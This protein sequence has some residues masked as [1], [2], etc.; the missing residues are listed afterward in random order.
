ME[1]IDFHT[2]ILPEMDDGA[3]TVEE[4]IQMLRGAYLSGAQTVLLTPHYLGREPILD[5][6]ARRKEKIAKLKDAM[7]DDGGLFPKLLAGAEVLLKGALSEHDDLKKLCIEGTNLLLLELPFPT[8]HQRHIQE[9]YDLVATHE[10][11]PVIAHIERYLSKPKEIEKLDQLI[12]LGAR[13][14]INAP[15]FL[16][17]SGKRVISVLAKQGLISAI[18]SDCHNTT[19]RPSDISRAVRAIEKRFGNAFVCDIYEKSKNLL[20][21]S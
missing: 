14:Q 7:K 15:S 13:F 21:S 19:S 1:Y 4:S 18:G 8:W 16:T 10:I 6:C 5:F 11:T 2:H 3:K 20:L 12:S 17:F 9:I